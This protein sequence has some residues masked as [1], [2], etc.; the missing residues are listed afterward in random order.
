MEITTRFA[1]ILVEE[2]RYSKNFLM[3]KPVPDKLFLDITEGQ[4]HITVCKYEFF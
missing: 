3:R 2:K 1:Y 4:Q